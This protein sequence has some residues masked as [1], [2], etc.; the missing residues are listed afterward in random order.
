MPLVEKIKD[1]LFWR[2]LKK[3]E[4][5]ALPHFANIVQPPVKPPPVYIE[6]IEDEEDYNEEEAKYA[7]RAAKI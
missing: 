4:K 2:K 6:L 3:A 1:A 7:E 5:T